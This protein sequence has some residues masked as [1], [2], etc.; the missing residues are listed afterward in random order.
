M[1]THVGIHVGMKKVRNSRKKPLTIPATSFFFTEN[2]C[3]FAENGCGSGKVEQ[4]IEIGI[5]GYLKQNISIEN[6]SITIANC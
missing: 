5:T 6:I 2:G 1:S 4:E 3:G